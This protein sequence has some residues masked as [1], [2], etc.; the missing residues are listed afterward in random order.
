V[1]LVLAEQRR[2]TVPDYAEIDAKD[3]LRVARTMGQ[4]ASADVWRRVDKPTAFDVVL[5]TAMTEEQR[6]RR[7][8]GHA[9][10]MV[11]EKLLLHVWEATASVIMPV[12]HPRVRARVLGFYRHEAL[13]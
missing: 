11:T 7:I 2:I 8:V 13:A 6:P 10:I 9:G 1:R 3:L 12:D 4:D 5:M